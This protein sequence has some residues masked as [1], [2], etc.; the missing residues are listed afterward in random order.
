MLLSTLRRLS[1]ILFCLLFANNAYALDFI[2]I[3]F[4]KFQVA[5][6]QWNTSSCYYNPSAYNGCQIY[7]KNPGIAYKIPFWNGQINWT[8]AGAGAYVKFEASGNSSYPYTAKVYK[9]DGTLYEVMG[10]GKVIYTGT[11]DGKALFF[12]MGNDNNTGQVFS[13]SKGLD[14]TG[15]FTMVG[16]AN[17]T[18]AEMD[19]YANNYGQT[20]PLASGELASPGAASTPEPIYSSSITQSQTSR[21][22]ANLPAT[23]MEANINIQGNSNLVDIVQ[24]GDAHYLELGIVGSSNAVDI[25]QASTAGGTHYLEA[26]V[27]GSKNEKAINV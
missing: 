18:T 1:S 22:S 27:N 6:S 15:G 13:I 20:D 26:T 21:R 7:S 10:T 11:V 14:N 24:A 16:T 23:G 9:S 25:E 3:K 17:P 12:F 8:G 4:S 5:D 19:T 2:D